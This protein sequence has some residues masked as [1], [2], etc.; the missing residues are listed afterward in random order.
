MATRADS[1]P[2]TATSDRPRTDPAPE[3]RF[4]RIGPVQAVAA[5]LLTG[6]AAV[7][8]LPDLLGGLD[9]HSPFVQLVSF[10]PWIVAGLLVLTLLVIA[11][12]VIW[13]RLWPFAAGLLA[14]A[15]GGSALLLPRIVPDPLPTGGRP[16]TVVAFNTSEGQAE[17]AAV[18]ELIS[19]E[20]PDLVALPEAGAWYAD[21]L[22]PLVEPLGYR[23]LPS[24]PQ[25]QPDGGGVTALASSGLG[26]VTV[27]YGDTSYPFVEVS[28]GDLG[29]LRFVAYHALSPR[30]ESIPVWRADVAR[31]AHWCAGPTP[32]IVAG[33]L[34]ATLDHSAL[35]ASVSGCGDAGEQRGRG[36]V[37]TWGPSSDTRMFGPQ[38]DHVLMTDGIA[39]ESFEVRDMPGSD[40]R[41]VVSRLRLPG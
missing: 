15:L 6:L 31:L 26:N 29:T 17:I 1:A 23:L 13:R 32:A 10:R 37:P 11:A 40:H 12:T 18:A 19:A 27:H 34:N 22:A 33:D 41:A 3:N 5:L 14:V 25:E 8:T 21:E 38:I 2:T 30:P 9:C 24:T 4:R 39:A 28:G 16:L 35:R 20:R 7:A 36:L